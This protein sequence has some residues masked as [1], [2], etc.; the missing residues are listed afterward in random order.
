MDPGA[1]RRSDRADPRPDE[2]DRIVAE[3]R[4]FESLL[5][6]APDALLVVD[7]RGTIVTVN[8][9]VSNVF[10]YARDEL[11]GASVELLLPLE[12]HERHVALRSDFQRDPSVRAMGM[13]RQLSGRKRD[14]TIFPVEVSLAPDRSS[15]E[16]IVIA[17]VRDVTEQRALE[18]RSRENEN[19]LLQ[20]AE[21]VET[22]FVLRQLEP[23]AHLYV[24]PASRA[25]FGVEPDEL[26]DARMWEATHPDDREQVEQTFRPDVLA[27]RSA[28]SEH[29]IVTPAGRSRWVRCVARPVANGDGPVERVVMTVEDID[30]RVLAADALRHAESAARA[31][32]AV[33]L[34]AS[35]AKN[36]FLSRMSHELRTPLNAVLGFGQLLEMRATDPDDV[37]AIRQLLKGGRH[38]LELINDVL[39]IA[40]IEAGETSVSTEPIAVAELV[41]EAVQLMTPMAETAGVSV[42]ALV[43]QADCF[44]LADR[45]RLRQVLLNLLSNAIK[46]NRRGG[47]V[48]L[49]REVTD[50][51]VAISVHDDGPGIPQELQHRLF[52]AFDRLGAEAGGVDGSGIGLTLTR[53]LAELMG[54]T[55]TFESA[56]GRGS[57]FTVTLPR[58]EPTPSVAPT[59]P[60]AHRTDRPDPADGPLTV[61]YIEDNEPNVRVVDHVVRLR[62]EWQLLH[63][64]LGSLGTELARAHRPELILLDLHLP[65]GSGADVLQRLKSDPATSPSPVVILTADAMARQAPRLL[66]LGA[67]R[68]VTKPLDVGELLAIL[69]EV[70]SRPR[71]GS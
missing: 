25:V 66:S 56:P 39:D 1:P 53:S 29:R 46:Y 31:A 61:L 11:V 13:G 51:H 28:Q 44:A 37:E 59:T 70:A 54:G 64:S 48:W 55:L 71:S 15:A 45:Q 36:E 10:G 60:A 21:S 41:E 35:Q 65:D 40:R 50:A 16:P 18:R 6:A 43:R 67:E 5:E 33:A 17:A 42:L 12:L 32:E 24:S 69:D 30:D 26:D 22:V 34:D 62:E 19:R 8:A 20:M 27:G 14:G 9:Q 2:A 58:A 68:Y 52:T 47:K 7:G 23:L 4:R 38:L 63:A 57:T 49:G 3:E